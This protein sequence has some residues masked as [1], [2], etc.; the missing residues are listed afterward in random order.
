MSKIETRSL[1]CP[2]SDEDFKLR[3]H[4]LAVARQRARALVDEKKAIATKYAVELKEIEAQIDSL[5]AVVKSK[6]EHRPVNVEWI[7]DHKSGT[8]R[9]ERL[10][11]GTEIDSRPMTMA[12]RQ[13][14]LNFGKKNG[15]AEKKDEPPTKGKKNG[16]AVKQAAPE[17]TSA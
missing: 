3:A 12:E 10:D 11:T 15:A 9:L 17:A 5:A 2:L 16:K 8:M 13:S 14:T 4:N 6:S 1:L 7:E